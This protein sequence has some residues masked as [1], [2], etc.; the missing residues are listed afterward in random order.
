M[1]NYDLEQIEKKFAELKKK[2]NEKQWN[3]PYYFRDLA[4]KYEKENVG[5]SFRLM[6]RAHN[7]KPD[8][9]IINEKLESYRQ[10]LPKQLVLGQE[11]VEENPVEQTEKLDFYPT[12]ISTI[13]DSIK[14]LLSKHSFFVFVF[15]PS[16]LYFLY[17]S[18]W[19]TERYES[20]SKIVVKQPDTTSTLV[21]ELALLGGVSSGA[22]SQDA[23]L[24]KEYI[25][26]YDMLKY[27]DSSL[28]VKSHY[29]NG[30]I[31]VFTRLSKEAMSEEF[32]EYYQSMVKIEVDSTSG[33]VSIYVKA[34]DA[35]FAK[36]MSRLILQMA[37]EFI[38]SISQQL[39]KSKLEFV[40]KEH[41]LASSK[42]NRAQN[43]LLE[44][45]Q[46]H[47][48]LDPESEGAAMQ[49]ITF[50]LESEIAAK[51]A[52]LN[53]YNKFMSRNSPEVIQ[54]ENVLQGLEQQLN[55]ER[56]RLAVENGSAPSVSS[57]LITYSQL[58]IEVELALQSY[59]AT[60][61]SLESARVEA[62]QQIKYLVKIENS[63]LP[64]STSYP[65]SGYNTVLFAV[66]LLL[67]YGTGRIIVA[68]ILELK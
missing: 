38:N 1:N 19:E 24:L 21:P 6:Q 68:T 40:N 56:K 55:D 47:E 50:K 32:L 44:Y 11:M 33:V 31:D 3:D 65:K 29:T 27:L 51:R 23:F 36:Q 45:Q 30:N 35:D 12:N 57:K 67:L 15:F 8:G 9:P 58:K 34:F 28:N 48:L 43:S 66:I 5:L 53:A 59:S 54:A 60:L 17:G 20:R 13:F 16:L 63:T 52:E 49:S 4:F 26:S 39:A 42:L 37:E 22:N 18:I 14:R 61:V 41:E 62:L 7:L 64:E 25:L 46:K 2:A 10:Q